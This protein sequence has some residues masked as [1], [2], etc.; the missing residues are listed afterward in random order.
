VF[1]KYVDAVEWR[2][3]VF[4]CSLLTAAESF[5]PFSLLLSISSVLVVIGLDSLVILVLSPQ[6]LQK[7]SVELKAGSTVGV[8]SRADEVLGSASGAL[9]RWDDIP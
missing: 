6:N 8:A 1:K 5:A 7:S 3:G 9:G 2:R 4:A